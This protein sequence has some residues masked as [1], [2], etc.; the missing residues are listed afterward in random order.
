MA[1][2]PEV[3]GLVNFLM[4][5]E[6]RV[7]TVMTH[8]RYQYQYDTF[9]LHALLLYTSILNLQ[10]ASDLNFEVRDLSHVGRA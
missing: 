2:G 9:L 5:W 6:G 8:Y 1:T 3:L 4:R 10:C 7:A